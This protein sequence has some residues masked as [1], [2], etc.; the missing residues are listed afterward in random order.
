[1]K[2]QSTKIVTALVAGILAIVLA[3]CGGGG[4]AVTLAAAMVVVG[5]V[6]LAAA[7]HR[8]LKNPQLPPSLSVNR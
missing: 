7:V 1:M 5:A 4:A 2:T 8:L 6:T 3:A